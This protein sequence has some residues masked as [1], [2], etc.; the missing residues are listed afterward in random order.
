L[1]KRL[2]TLISVDDAVEL[3]ART[4]DTAVSLEPEEV[5]VLEA[6]GRIIAEPVEAEIDIPPFNRSAVDGYAVRAGDTVSASVYNP[7]ELVLKGVLTPSDKPPSRCVEPGEAVRVHTGSPIPCGAD[8]VVMDEDVEVKDDSVVVYKPVSPGQNISRRGEDFAKGDIIIA[9]GTILN[10]VHIG[11]ISSIGVDRVKVYRRL[12]IGVLTSGNEVCEPGID[13][14]CGTLIYNSS[15]R[16]ITALLRQNRFI[17]VKYYGVFP[18]DPE[19]L[20]N[21]VVEASME[22]DL[23]VT[24]GGTGVSESDALIDA[25][26]NTGKIVFRGVKMRPGR[27]TTLSLI[28]NKP[29]LH[30][31]GYPVAAWTGYE[32]I[33]IPAV[34][35]WLELKGLER[36]MVYARLSRRIPNTV[37]YRSYIR[38]ILRDAGGGYVAEPYMLRGSGVLSSL[39]KSHGYIVVPENVEGIEKDSAV[40]VYLF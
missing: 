28:N 11:V 12:R 14:D 31:S 26:L 36:P 35:K 37:G 32:A 30:L 7:V 38:V 27:P 8:A 19:I 24:T 10:P 2:T 6:V 1:G 13:R 20:S 3:L 15:A 17:D 22:N 9:R 4:L 34:R 29:V 23:V 33:L 5:R 39:L 16:L 40:P 18:D 25:M 21:A